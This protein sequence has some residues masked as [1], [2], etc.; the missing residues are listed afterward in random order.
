LT[1]RGAADDIELLSSRPFTDLTDAALK[2]RADRAAQEMDLVPADQQ[3]RVLRD[4]AALRDEMIERLLRRGD[5]DG[6]TG[7]REPRE[8][9]PIDS[10]G[11]AAVEQDE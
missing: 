1:P 2:A 3:E 10:A 9:G 6:T 4:I 8:P 11:A 5:D 7:V